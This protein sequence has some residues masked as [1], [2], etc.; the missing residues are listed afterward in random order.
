MGRSTEKKE[1]A[2]GNAHYAALGDNELILAM[3]RDEEQAFVEFIERLRM[4]AWNQARDLGIVASERRSWTEEILHDCALALVRHGA[5][6]PVNLSGYVVVA[7]RRKFFAEIRKAR[8]EGKLA[9]RLAQELP[10][11]ATQSAN[12]PAATLPE[13]VARLTDRLSRIL[14]EQEELLL[15]WKGHRITYSTIAEW[16]GESRNTVAQRTWRLTKRV[17]TEAEVIIASFSEEERDV[18]WRFLHGEE[19]D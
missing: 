10:G 14:T 12:E 7:V 13:P 9:D 19:E 1:V 2:P 11:E 15:I 18:I 4:V 6:V 8:S 3:R 17:S 5:N 16:L